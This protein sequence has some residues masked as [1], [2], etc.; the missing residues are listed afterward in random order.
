MTSNASDTPLIDTIASLPTG[1]ALAGEQT[2]ASSD[3][4][5]W[6]TSYLKG[7]YTIV[8]KRFF[9]VPKD[10]FHWQSV[11][12]FVGNAIEQPLGA[13]V[14]RYDWHN[15]GYDLVSVWIIP[16]QPGKRIAVAG[17]RGS[18]DGADG[19]VGYFEL[20]GDPLDDAGVCEKSTANS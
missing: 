9:S 15:P 2:A 7:R 6:M 12:K 5:D 11:A 16:G 4:S 18:A 8:S 14:E 1:T 20:Q 3:L 13:C 19:I 10:E 17:R